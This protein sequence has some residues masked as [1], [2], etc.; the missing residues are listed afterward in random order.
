MR[1]M[2]KEQEGRDLALG[3]AV[4]R[5]SKLFAFLNKQIPKQQILEL[6]LFDEDSSA[7][8]SRMIKT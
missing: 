1:F 8:V 2:L 6:P 3:Q 5:F 7:L 4:Y